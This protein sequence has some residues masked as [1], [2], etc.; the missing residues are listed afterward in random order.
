MRYPGYVLCLR[1][2]YGYVQ[3]WRYESLDSWMCYGNVYTAGQLEQL[4]VSP[5]VMRA[6]WE[7]MLA[8]ISTMNDLYRQSPFHIITSVFSIKS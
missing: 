3:A 5:R 2:G 8:N 4:M 7:S 6:R 1:D